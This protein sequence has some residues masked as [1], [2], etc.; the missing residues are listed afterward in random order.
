MHHSSTS[1]YTAN[2]IEIEETFCG[3]TDGQTYERTFETHFIRS[4]TVGQL[5]GVD[6]N[7]AYRSYTPKKHN[8]LHL[9]VN[10]SK[11][12]IQITTPMVT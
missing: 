4:T 6:L 2:F 8:R 1:T 3:R 5:G 7:I 10:G 9:I 12:H 11:C